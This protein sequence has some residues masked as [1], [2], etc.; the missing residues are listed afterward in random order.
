M[1]LTKARNRMITGAHINV[2]DFGAVGDGVTDDTVAV[3]AAITASNGTPVVFNA[4]KTFLCG[5]FSVP[6][7]AHLII[8]GT[9]KASLT[10]IDTPLITGANISNVIIEGTGN[11]DGGYNIA[12][13]YQ[14]RSAT[15]PTTR[16]DGSALQVGDT[17]YDTATGVEKF[18]QYSG[19]AWAIITISRTG[20]KLNKST[21]CLIQGISVANFMLTESPGTDGAGIWLE[22]DPDGTSAVDSARNSCVNVTSYSNIGNGIVFGANLDSISDSCYAY[23]NFWGSGVA[24][25]R[26]LRATS[27]SDR[28]SGN[29][30]SNL[31]INCEDSQVVTPNSRNSGYSGINIGH[32]SAASDASRTLVIGGVSENN[33]FEG[34]SV[35]G[36]DDV[37]IFG[38]YCNNNGANSGANDRYGVRTLAGCNRLHLI[39]LKVTASKNSGIYL[40]FGSGHR[41]ESCKSYA[42][43]RTGMLLVVTECNISDCEIFNNN[44]LGG[45]NRAGLQAD[46][47]NVT[48]TDC[49]IYDDQASPTQSYG[50]LAA[51]KTI[52]GVVKRAVVRLVGCTLLNNII[53]PTILTRTGVARYYQTRIGTDPMSGSFQVISGS[54][55][56]VIAND[57]ASDASR[58]VLIPRDGQAAAKN[59]FPV[60]V[61]IG[62]SFGVNHNAAGGNGN[63]NY[64]I[65]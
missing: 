65:M 41:V 43:N 14:G 38:T 55:S 49:H 39:G 5:T 45:A 23:D 10:V 12:V 53:S 13:G 9:I 19:S 29:E 60:S 28:L 27:T 51:D 59:A 40:Q 62:A 35:A 58:I 50:V 34:I 2:L 61:V 56:I 22:G 63:F 15:E 7:N 47:G 11:L 4:G 33:N 8:N 6:S 48:V 44:Q 3:Q 24:H 25:T 18:K 31:T 42:N 20:I 54:T 17:F 32:D 36:S 64:L 1:A 37:T 30:F 57:N 21:D 52:G 26:G 46:T 16:T